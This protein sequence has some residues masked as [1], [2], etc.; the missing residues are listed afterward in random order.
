M[1]PCP[2]GTTPSNRCN[3]KTEVISA[4]APRW[5]NLF[6]PRQLVA[7]TTFSDLVGE[8]TERIRR[9]AVATGLPDDNRPLR[10]G[11]TGATAYAN[12]VA[13]YLSFAQSKS[14]NRNTSLC[15]WEHRMDRLVAT[16]GRQA[17]P[18]VWDFAETNPLAGAGGDIFGSV[19]SVCEVIEKQFQQTIPA[20]ASQQDA[21][22][23]KRSSGRLVSTDPPYYDNIGYAD[24]SDFFYIWLR[25]S[26]RNMFPDLFA[27]VAV[28][29]GAELVAS[30]YRHGSKE[31]ADIF[32]LNGMT[33]AL[34]RLADS[35]H[36]GF[37]GHDLLCLQAI[38]EQGQWNGEHRL[39][40]LPGRSDQVRLCSYGHLAH[41]HGAAE[42][43]ACIRPECTRLQRRPRLSPP[44][45][46][47]S[48]RHAPRVRD[49]PAVGVAA[50]PPSAANRQHRPRRPR[51]GRHRPRH[52]RLHSLRAV[53]AHGIRWR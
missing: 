27:T 12:A 22:D 4:L 43:A 9:D 51:P 42:G 19:E 5:G 45:H 35:A 17:L 39:G 14:C 37:P 25:R 34:R 20:F 40:G 24:L 2:N 8:A 48:D 33:Q 41:A 46:G 13:V 26:L 23:Q 52:G 3:E 38:G 32:F 47:C 6:T 30:A 16:F 36:P 15:L 18:M 21:L 29:K 49:R 50:G 11:G 1:T 7:L 31:A 10:D 53:L 44:S 28:P